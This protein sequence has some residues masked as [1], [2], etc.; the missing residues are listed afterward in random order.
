MHYSVN[1]DV[2]WAVGHSLP[3]TWAVG[4]SLTFLSPSKCLTTLTTFKI[5]DITWDVGHFFNLFIMYVRGFAW[6]WMALRARNTSP[7]GRASLNPQSTCHGPRP[8]PKLLYGVRAGSLCAT[9][10]RARGKTRGRE[11]KKCRRVKKT[12][13]YICI[14]GS[15]SRGVWREIPGVMLVDEN[16][17]EGN[18][19]SHSLFLLEKTRPKKQ[20]DRSSEHYTI[21]AQQSCWVLT[22]FFTLNI[23]I[24]VQLW[25][26]G[27]FPTI[28]WSYLPRK[29][30]R[31][32]RLS[33]RSLEIVSY[34]TKMV[35]CFASWCRENTF[36]SPSNVWRHWR[37]SRS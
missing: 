26:A 34:C 30:V 6:A 32:K 35:A 33:L 12:R 22:V 15:P 36:P 25:V 18:S 19:S 16:G 29:I 10:P 27:E 1:I 8:E 4:P 5:P 11:R 2:T 14:Q 3:C 23:I 37:C 17:H 21:L 31:E 13:F 20:Q 7:S 9:E 28:E 24:L